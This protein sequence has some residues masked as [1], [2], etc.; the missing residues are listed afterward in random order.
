MSELIDK[1][2]LNKM[3]FFEKLNTNLYYKIICN[4][5]ILRL[6][7]WYISS[8]PVHIIH[9]TF[10]KYAIDKAKIYIIVFLS[11]KIDNIKIIEKK[12]EKIKIINILSTLNF[13]ELQFHDSLLFSAYEYYTGKR[14]ITQIR[15]SFVKLFSNLLEDENIIFIISNPNK[16]EKIKIYYENL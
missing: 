11:K 2:F 14:I 16:W 3:S 5:L 13:A 12:E 8:P 1:E 15:E 6:F 9:N 4:N 7:Y 10:N